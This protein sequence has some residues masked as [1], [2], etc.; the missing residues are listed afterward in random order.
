MNK[1]VEVWTM[2]IPE[3]VL[4]A[5]FS[6]TEQFL[7]TGDESAPISIPPPD[8]LATQWCIREF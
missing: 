1:G 3:P 4:F 8:I 6:E 2:N 7:N 5:K